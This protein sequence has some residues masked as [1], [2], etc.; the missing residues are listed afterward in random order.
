MSAPLLRAMG[1]PIAVG[2]V[3]L[4]RV[5]DPVTGAERVVLTERA[6]IDAELAVLLRYLLTRLDPVRFVGPTG[7]RVGLDA[8]AVRNAARWLAQ[9]STEQASAL[10]KTREWTTELNAALDGRHFALKLVDS[11][12]DGLEISERES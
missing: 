7:E 6:V 9:Q 8:R 11:L 12:D 4:H 5:V 1:A 2:P 10:A 3:E